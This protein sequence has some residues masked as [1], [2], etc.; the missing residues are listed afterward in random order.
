MTQTITHINMNKQKIIFVLTFFIFS[1]C[2][3]D[4]DIVFNGFE[5]S[6]WNYTKEVYDA[7]MIIGGMQ[8]GV[9]KPTDSIDVNQIKV[10]Q[11]TNPYYFIGENRWKPDLDKIKAIPSQHCYFKIRLSPHR[12][13]MIKRSGQS[14]ILSLML[15][16]G[17]FFTGDYGSLIFGIRDNEVTGRAAKEL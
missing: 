8:N 11:G 5:F 12:E 14:Q 7:K 16:N 6:F 15:P 2:V 10:G 13:E 4:E 1:S 3:K 17:D 9:F